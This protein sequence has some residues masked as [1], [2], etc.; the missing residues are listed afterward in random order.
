MRRSTKVEVKIVRNG[1][2]QSIETF[3][4]EEA[5]LFAKYLRREIKKWGHGFLEFYKL[6]PKKP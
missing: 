4:N 2:H 6:S 1:E 5:L 3:I